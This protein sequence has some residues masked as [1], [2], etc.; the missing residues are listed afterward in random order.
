MELLFCFL[1]NSLFFLL[2]SGTWYLDSSLVRV[3]TILLMKALSFVLITVSVCFP[4]T[5]EYDIGAG[6]VLDKAGT[7]ELETLE[8]G[9]GEILLGPNVSREAVTGVEALIDTL[10]KEASENPSS[11]VQTVQ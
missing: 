8:H 7:P 9:T 11:E 10:D 1:A 2:R 5:I 4:F 6:T 3:F